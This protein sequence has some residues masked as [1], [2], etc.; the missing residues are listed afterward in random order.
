MAKRKK[1]EDELKILPGT[2]KAGCGY[3]Q[4]GDVVNSWPLQT[5]GPVEITALVQSIPYHPLIFDFIEVSV[6]EIDTVPKGTI[7]YLVVD[8]GNPANPFSCAGDP[9]VINYE[10]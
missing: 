9:T 1:V 8:H 7:G 3:Y 5:P 2:V 10:K 4:T 6:A